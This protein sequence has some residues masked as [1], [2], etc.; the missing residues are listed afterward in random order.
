M[1]AATTGM[2]NA[3]QGLDQALDA[4]RR[5]GVQ[6]GNWRWVVRQ[7][8]NAVR[9]A[10]VIE[11]RTP[12][13]TWLAAR[14]GTAFRQRN[15]LLGRLNDLAPLILESPD[16]EIIRLDMKRLLADIAHHLQRLHDLA[17][18]DVEIELGGSE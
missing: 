8:M 3:L 10:L 15:A 4:P 6:L 9:D 18:D 11:V 17:Y 2:S 1:A 13:D 12:D 16:V 5:P 14:G 7:R